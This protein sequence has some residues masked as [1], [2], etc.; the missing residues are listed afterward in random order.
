VTVNTDIQ[1]VINNIRAHVD[2]LEQLLAGDSSTTAELAVFDPERDTPPMTPTVEG[3]RSE[4][5]WCALM[6][7][8]QLRAIN[9]RQGRGATPQES[10]E[11]AKAAGYRDGRAWNQWGGWKK[12]DH[13]NRWVV[14][15]GMRALRHYYSA[16]GRAL[17][18]DLT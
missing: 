17:P 16:V 4:R 10:R 9:V 7:W 3:N 2:R 14:E 6:L 18:G 15:P 13:G 12:D 11:I 8:A 1:E 5:D